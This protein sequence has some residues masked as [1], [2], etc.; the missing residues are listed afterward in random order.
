MSLQEYRRRLAGRLSADDA[1][2]ICNRIATAL[3]EPG[4]QLSRDALV[5]LCEV[6][7]SDDEA[8]A[9]V[10][11]GAIFA[12]L[13]EPLSDS[14]S[15]EAAAVYDRLFTWVIEWC[16]RH[17]GG[18]ELDALLRRFGLLTD[19][20]FGSRRARLRAARRPVAIGQRI[21]RVVV[22]SR[23]T[24]GA[25]V[26]VTSVV[27]RK[28]LSTFPEAEVVL[29]A[30]R[31]TR[32]IL[33]GEDRLRVQEVRYDRQGTLLGRLSTW[34]ALVAAVD[35]E[36]GGADG[37]VLVVDP[38]SRLT[39]LGLLPVVD[40]DR[41]YSFFESRTASAPGS[42]A[43]GELTSRWADETFGGDDHPRPLVALRPDD[44]RFGARAGAQLRGAGVSRIAAVNFGIGGNDR[45]RVSEEFE[46]GLVTSLVQAG[47]AVILDKGVGTEVER[48]DRV[49]AALEEDGRTVRALTESGVA[50]PADVLTWEGRI[51]PFAALIASSDVYLGYDSAFQHIAA[52]LDVPVIDVFADA[53]SPLF[54]ERW[55]PWSRAPV[56]VV[57]AGTDHRR[58][59]DEAIAHVRRIVS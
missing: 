27:V 41:G 24:V 10:G 46:R 13:V 20:D 18:G 37:D 26:A 45:K 54:V 48:V 57:H 15:P 11:Q 3:R 1:R 21:A 36:R 38:D 28:L 25:D 43:L 51:G 40:G 9:R 14:F 59:V 55:T 34:R 19:A 35:A 5:F 22:L 8:L 33:V 30:P 49:V 6:A 4:A 47:F 58:A 53:P 32:E 31:L 44:E 52:A 7:S 39:Q 12:S 2:E 56:R 23:V 29:L 17:P 42:P 50:A 16:R